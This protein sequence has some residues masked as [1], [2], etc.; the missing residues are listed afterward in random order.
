MTAVFLPLKEEELIGDFLSSWVK[1]SRFPEHCT[2]YNYVLSA[3]SEALCGFRQLLSSPFP[4]LVETTH[5][6]VS[7][8]LPWSLW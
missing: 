8:L 7:Q 2:H 4:W 5:S 1:R 3:L 6:V